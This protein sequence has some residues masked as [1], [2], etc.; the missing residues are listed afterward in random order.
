MTT[1]KEQ[2]EA[3][4]AKRDARIEE[5]IGARDH[6]RLQASMQ[7][8]EARTQ[9][10]IVAEIG[11]MVGEPCD[12]L[13]ASAVRKALKAQQASAVHLLFDGQ[14]GPECGRFVEAE[15]P[16]GKSINAGEWSQRPDGYWQLVIQQPSAGVVP[17][18][19]A[20]CF[21]HALPDEDDWEVHDP[22]HMSGDCDGCVRAVIVSR[23]TW[24]RL[25]PCRAQA[26][27]DSE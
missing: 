27:G 7:A 25:N 8:Q 1:E 6:L 5:L 2:L 23:D 9:K 17:G 26:S 10:A 16:T 4:I 19:L 11:A 18:V 13:T 3:E 24:D 21:F 22:R 12:W 14:P 20:E 15:D